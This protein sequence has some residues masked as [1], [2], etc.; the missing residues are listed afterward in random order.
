MPG[1]W[2]HH[3]LLRTCASLHL[4]TH[5]P[6]TQV[7]ISSRRCTLLCT[8]V[9]SQAGPRTPIF[10]VSAVQDTQIDTLPFL[11]KITQAQWG[12]A[13]MSQAVYLLHTTV[14]LA[15]YKK[16]GHFD[17]SAYCHC[18]PRMTLLLRR[19]S[20]CIKPAFPVEDGGPRTVNAACE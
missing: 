11:H 18:I 6:C 13:H 3:S 9:K 4:D 10:P 17:S 12:L 7:H 14:L 8:C 20:L 5:I 16:K 1:W 15:I 2:W 19:A